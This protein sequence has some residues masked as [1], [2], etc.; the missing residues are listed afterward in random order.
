MFESFRIGFN[1]TQWVVMTILGLY[2]WFLKKQSASAKEMHDIRIASETA[3][4]DIRLR[5]TEL[6]SAVKDMPSKLEIARLEGQIETIKTQL[7][8]ANQ[9]IGQVQRGVLRIEQWLIDNKK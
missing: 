8:S 9:N 5:V 2:T 3:M 1:E 7:N 4:L 6:E